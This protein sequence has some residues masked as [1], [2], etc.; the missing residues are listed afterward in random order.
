METSGSEGPRFRDIANATIQHAGVSAG[1]DHLAAPPVLSSMLLGN[2][3][4]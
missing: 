2:S 3:Q 4:T 1:A